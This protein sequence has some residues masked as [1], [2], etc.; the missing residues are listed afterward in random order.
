M[1]KSISHKAGAATKLGRTLREAR[2]SARMTQKQVADASGVTACYVCR[3]EKGDIDIPPAPR[4]VRK[5]AESL[6]LDPVP[7]LK[8]TGREDCV[9]EAT[10]IQA[11]RRD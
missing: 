7:L 10:R 6:G 9:R 3:V 5:A 4:F 1:P 11:D 8:M 2:M